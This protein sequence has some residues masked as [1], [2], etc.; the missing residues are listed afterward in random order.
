M[1]TQA[2]TQPTTLDDLKALNSMIN[3][4]QK[5]LEEADGFDVNELYGCNWA[6]GSVLSTV[7]EKIEA[8]I[9]DV[10]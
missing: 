5:I 10:S 9:L 6:A 7:S 2:Q 4:A 1:A 3:A 8:M